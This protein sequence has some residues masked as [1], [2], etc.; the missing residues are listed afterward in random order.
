[1]SFPVMAPSTREW[2]CKKISDLQIASDAGIKMDV[3]G[4]SKSFILKI[5]YN[6]DK[7]FFIHYVNIRGFCSYLSPV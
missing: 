5:N 7:L 6:G 1:M 3:H 2:G 4:D